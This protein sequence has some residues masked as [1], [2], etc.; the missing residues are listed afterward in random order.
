MRR[1]FSRLR[2]DSVWRAHVHP[3]CS[4]WVAEKSDGVRVLLFVHTDLQTKEQA[5]YLASAPSPLASAPR[6][7]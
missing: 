2:L 1:C 6:R 7:R 3:R 5:V 4:Y